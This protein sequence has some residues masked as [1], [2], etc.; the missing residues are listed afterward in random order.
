VGWIDFITDHW[1]WFASPAVLGTALKFLPNVT[2][3]VSKFFMRMRDS[4]KV[5][6]VCEQ[7][8]KLSID[9]HTEMERENLFLS[10]SRERLMQEVELLLDQVERLRISSTSSN[11]HGWDGVD[12]RQNMTQT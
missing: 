1:A 11:V 2:A 9:R 3:R 6:I 4:H 5:L 8:L 7:Q 12:R 10:E